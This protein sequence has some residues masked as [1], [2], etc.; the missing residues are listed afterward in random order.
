VNNQVLGRIGKDL[1][2]GPFIRYLPSTK[3]QTGVTDSMIADCVE[4]ARTSPFPPWASSLTLHACVV[5]VRYACV[6]SCRALCAAFIG[7]LFLEKGLEVVEAFVRVVFLPRLEDMLATRQYLDP[8]SRLSQRHRSAPP[9]YTY[10]CASPSPQSISSHAMPSSHPQFNRVVCGSGQV[11]ERNGTGAHAQVRGGGHGAWPAQ[12]QGQRLHPRQ[13][14]TEYAE[15]I[16][17]FIHSFIHLWCWVLLVAV[18][19]CTDAANDAL[20]RD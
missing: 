3:E 10:A 13:R 12:G 16:A 11:A 17:T 20:S 15:P 2:F 8:K 1:G 6:V 18:V 5:R 4:G 19:V 14:R 9:T 7:A